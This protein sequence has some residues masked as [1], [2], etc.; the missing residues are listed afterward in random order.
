MYVMQYIHS[1]ID[2]WFDLKQLPYE[3]DNFELNDVMKGL[4][5]KLI[6]M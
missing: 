4:H 3:E 6:A 5:E 1:C 2:E